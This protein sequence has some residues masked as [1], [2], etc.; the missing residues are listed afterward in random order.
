MATTTKLDKDEHGKDVEIKLYGSMIESLLYLT[1]S[2]S[3]IMFS[4]FLRARLQLCPKEASKYNKV[5]Y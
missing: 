2:R 1:T 4:V 5:Y 3:D